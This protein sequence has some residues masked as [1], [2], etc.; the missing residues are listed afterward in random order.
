MRRYRRGRE[1]AEDRD[2]GDRKTIT[3]AEGG[4]TRPRAL[5]KKGGEARAMSP[6]KKRGSEIA[7]KAAANRW[8]HR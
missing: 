5:G 7:K 4:R 1:G 6:S 3:E 8:R 2:R